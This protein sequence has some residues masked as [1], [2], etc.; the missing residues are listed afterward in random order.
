MFNDRYNNNNNSYYFNDN[1]LSQLV[2]Q[3]NRLFSQL[4]L[5]HE[6]KGNCIRQSLIATEENVIELF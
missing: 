1:S 4:N 3:C 2:F 5:R 6:I